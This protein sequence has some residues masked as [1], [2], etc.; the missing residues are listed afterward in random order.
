MRICSKT[1]QNMFGIDPKIFFVVLSEN[2]NKKKMSEE[3]EK[4]SPKEEI[5]EKEERKPDFITSVAEV[6]FF[7]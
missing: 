6:P 5:E 2:K 3:E 1:N 4:L 7:Y